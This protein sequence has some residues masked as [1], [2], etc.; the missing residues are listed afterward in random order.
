[1][2]I[3][4]GTIFSSAFLLF[5]VQPIIA[6][7]ILPWFGGSSMVWTICLVFFQGVLLAGYAYSDYISRHL[8]PRSQAILHIL[9]LM[10]ALFTLPIV[11]DPS[12]KPNG[13][14]DPT[15][16]ILGLLVST[17]GLPYFLLST[18]GPLVQSWCAGVKR[19]KTVYRLFSLSNLAS[20]TA[21][22]SYPFIVEPHVLT[23]SQ[24]KAWSAVFGVFIFL[25]SGAAL[26]FVRNHN[27]EEENQAVCCEN[28]DDSGEE[29]PGIREMILW[30]SLSAMGSWMLL[31]IS[32]HITQNIAS[33]PFLWILPLTIYL[34]TFVFCFERDGWYQ[35][36]LYLAP[37]A[38]LLGT[39]AWGLQTHAVTL[40]IKIAIPLY[41]AGLFVLCM[42][43]HGELATRKPGTRFLTRFY[44][45]LSLG[46]AL[47]GILV[48]LVAPRILPAYYELGIGFIL[49]ALLAAIIFYRQNRILASG[50]MAMSLLCGLFLFLQISSEYANAREVTR[51]FYGSLR[52]RDKG[53]QEEGQRVRQLKHGAIL[54]G[55]QFLSPARHNEATT[56]YG[57]TSG[58]G[59]ALLGMQ[60]RPL[61]VGVIGMGTATLA[62]YGRQGDYFRFYEINPKVIDLARREFTFLN[63]GKGQFDIVLGDAR[64]SLE[65]EADQSF[66]LLAVD[67]FSGDSIPVHLL[68]REAMTIYL[69]HLKSDGV[70]AFHVTN[71][72]LKLAPVVRTLA[73][74]FGMESVRVYDEAKDSDLLRSDWVLVSRNKTFLA[75]QEIAGCATS[76]DDIA[77][78]ALWTD[79][80][81]N[82]FD[83][84]K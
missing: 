10:I 49:T 31:A 12:W 41:M 18:T 3:F 1:M 63:E 20:L 62:A 54:H 52:T 45:M 70:L 14:E 73:C 30:L 58:V 32:N 42:F 59:R 5:L 19:C 67:A 29:V 61:R 16:R 84:L 55:E 43:F 13:N 48:G 80:F 2:I 64:L 34:I 28:L 74:F 79:D 44:L 40:K 81:N 23:L 78:L 21:L 4:A 25:C 65:R 37:V 27:R 57:T 22:I 68:T 72:F 60:N 17:I 47:G 82:L 46:G 6:K 77:G 50:A 7:Q 53:N 38:L 11:A 71:R 75:G 15:W 9:L 35:R 51:N 33:I 36:N 76:I 66:D 69:R 56:Y 24:N 39:C 8:A 26:L 83:V